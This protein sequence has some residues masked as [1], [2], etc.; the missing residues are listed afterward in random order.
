MS[1]FK[2]T[3]MKEKLVN[4]LTEMGSQASQFWTRRTSEEFVDSLRSHG[5]KIVAVPD[6]AK[7]SKMASKAAK[8][9]WK[10]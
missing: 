9:R 5:F 10:A 6:A 4:V 1:Q 8:A 7:R 3:A 2:G